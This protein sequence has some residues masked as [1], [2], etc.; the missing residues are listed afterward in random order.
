L[1][2][3]LYSIL[4]LFSDT[5]NI[6][7]QANNI[8]KDKFS[9]FY[10]LEDVIKIPKGQK[11]EYVKIMKELQIYNLSP[12]L[13]KNLRK[14]SSHF[15]GNNKI[16]NNIVLKVKN[17]KI[18]KDKIFI[19]MYF[20]NNSEKQKIMLKKMPFSCSFFDNNGIVIDI[21]EKDIPMILNPKEIILV[22]N[23]ELNLSNKIKNNINSLKQIECEIEK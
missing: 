1:F 17:Y 22:K 7:K 21:L 14:T 20:Y 12:S 8:E 9:E 4:D 10:R 23:I 3:F 13:N 18:Q 11:K 16:L 5:K 6:F 15:S 19:D 2:L